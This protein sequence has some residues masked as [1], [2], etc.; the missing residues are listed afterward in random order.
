ML[1]APTP[2][3]YPDYNCEAQYSWLG[4]RRDKFSRDMPA[5]TRPMK[6]SFGKGGRSF[7]SVI[8]FHPLPYERQSLFKGLF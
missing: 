4:A 6:N 8:P 7:D 1:I 5:A 2:S 3:L